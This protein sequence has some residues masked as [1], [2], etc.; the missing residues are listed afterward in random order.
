MVMS[1]KNIQKEI[2]RVYVF[3]YNKATAVH[4]RNISI[5]TAHVCFLQLVLQF[6][7]VH[8]VD[9]QNVHF[10]VQFRSKYTP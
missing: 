5:N 1:I 7:N 6:L 8:H 4:L 9:L 3:H 2:G 10:K